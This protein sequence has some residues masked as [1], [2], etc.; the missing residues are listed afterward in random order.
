MDARISSERRCSPRVQQKREQA[1]REILEA[2]QGLLQDG[3]LEAVTLASVAGELSMT[4]QAIYHYFTSKEALVRSLV[5]ELI[6]DEVGALIEAVESADSSAA[7]L[8]ILIR[9][10]Y[11]HYIN[12]LD[13]LRTVY[14]Q[15]QLYAAPNQGVDKET[16]R[17]EI[18]PRTQHLFDR[19]EAR[20]VA[21]RTMSKSKRERLR[22]LA[23]TA[24]TSALGLM[25]MLG[26]ADAL[27]DPLVHTD[28]DLIDT[29]TEV[30]GEI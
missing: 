7:P 9:A 19:L 11:D 13:S 16:V 1:R 6:D 28:E 21:D 8:G 12:N 25:T 23:F 4:K 24:W 17:E 14:C 10:F 30:F 22:R 20:L 2:A 26:I 5:T 27:N 29:L 18:N 3:G 15:S